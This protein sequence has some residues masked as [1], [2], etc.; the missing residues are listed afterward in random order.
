MQWF[1]SPIPQAIAESKRLNLPFLV[2]ISGE[3]EDSQHMLETWESDEIR[4]ICQ[5]DKCVPIKIAANSPTSEQFAAIYPIVCIPS[6]FVIGQSGL[7]LEVVGGYLPVADFSER[8]QKAFKLFQGELNRTTPTADLTQQPEQSIAQPG[9]MA[10]QPD[11]AACQQGATIDQTGDT[12][13]QAD[14]SA[15]QPGTAAGTSGEQSEKERQE[16]LERAQQLVE[17]IQVQKLQKEKEEEKRK[18]IERRNV[19]RGVQ[20]LRATQK[21]LE[22]KRDAEERKKDKQEERVARERIRQQIAE[23]RADKTA[24]FQQMAQ[25][26]ETEAQDAKRRKLQEEQKAA[27]A[28]NA[29][30][31]NSARLQFRLP[32]GGYLT[33]TFAAGD[34]FQEA[35]DYVR[36]EVGNKYGKYVLKMSF[37]KRDF[38][39]SDYSQTMRDLELAPSAVLLLVPGAQRN[40]L[41]ARATGDGSF[42]WMVLAPFFAIFNFMRRLVFGDSPPP[43]PPS[44]TIPAGRVNV[45]TD[46]DRRRVPT[47]AYS[48]YREGNLTRLRN[49]EGDDDDGST[50][51]GNSTQQ[52]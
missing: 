22:M 37:P 27:A 38:Q 50:W 7:P 34:R 17:Q 39:P 21:E 44:D 9:D 33:H 5:S 23:D 36:Q 31:S 3:D 13:G 4:S 18:E 6:T 16:R 19:G 42:F 52:L 24:R 12:E 35:V 29:A 47:S 46:S 14:D 30:S 25:D 2:Y 20:Q 28:R 51:N 40:V 10:E 15:E 11:D 8:L 32:D 26:R 45:P 48:T 49:V 43:T 41:P 1:S